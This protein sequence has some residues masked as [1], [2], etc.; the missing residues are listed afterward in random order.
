MD[1]FIVLGRYQ[2]FH[3][4]HEYL[5]K[6]AYSMMSDEDELV[7]A[8]GSQ[9]AGWEP[10][11]P[12]TAD[13]RQAMIQTW[14]DAE[15]IVCTIV[16]IED[17]NDPPNWVKHA[18]KS[19]G[20]GTLVT[21]DLEAKQ[22]YDDANFKVEMLEMNER[23]R[24]EGWRIRQTAK[25]LSTVY[26]DDAVREVLKESIPRAVIEWLIENDALFRLSTF[27]TGVYAG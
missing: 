5:V 26:D 17:I 2:P 20:T 25:M 23:D 24:L 22:L 13:E 4:G 3:K 8:I 10:N 9:Q 21:T 27:E 12:W 18:Q 14:A 7:V 11:N 1:R 15:D 6:T 16:S 19:H